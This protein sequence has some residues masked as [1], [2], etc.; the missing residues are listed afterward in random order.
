MLVLLPRTLAKGTVACTLRTLIL[1]FVNQPHNAP[2]S[3]SELFAILIC[4]YIRILNPH[5]GMRPQRQKNFRLGTLSNVGP[6]V[7]TLQNT[8]ISKWLQQTLSSSYSFVKVLRGLET[9]GEIKQCGI[10]SRGRSDPQE[11]DSAGSKITETIFL[12]NTR[13]RVSD[14]SESDPRKQRLSVNSKPN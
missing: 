8:Y 6:C 10:R 1:F 11:S 9:I 12:Y 3:S 4:R 14:P 13:R 2:D 7:E 5:S